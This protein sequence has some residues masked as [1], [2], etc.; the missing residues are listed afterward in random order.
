MFKIYRDL[1]KLEKERKSISVAI[2]GSGKMGVSLLSLLIKL[3][4]FDP[5]ILV[6]RTLSKAEEAYRRFGIKNIARVSSIE[7][8][9]KALEA[10]DYLVSADYRIAVESK[11]IDVVVDAT[12]IPELGAEI[13]LA[14]F[15]NKK[16]VVMLNVECDAVIGPILR[17]KAMEAGVVYTGTK[18]DEPGAI[19]DLV[20]F[21]QMIGAE[22]QVVGKGKNNKLDPYASQES[23]KIDAENKK[24]SQ[25][26]MTSFVDGTNT[27]IE[28]T[29]VGNALGF[30]PDI[31]GCHGVEAKPETCAKIFSLKKDG[32][33]LSSLKTVDF[34]FGMA[35][36]VF[37]VVSSDNEEVR[38]ILT[39]LGF[40]EG[41]LFTLFRPYHL[42]SLETPIS[43]YNAVI[44]KETSI[45]A[46][47]GR[48]CDTI[49]VSK[50]DFAK[51]EKLEGIGSDKVFGRI[52]SRQD[53]EKG[54][55][56]PIGLINDKTSFKV[57]VKKGQHIT[58]DMVELDRD[59]LLT[60]LR[61]EQD[62]LGL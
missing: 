2:V 56:L 6:N 55:Y 58:Y 37:A 26:M 35:P 49:A 7:E 50:G 19:V 38:D 46:E 40:G 28:L 30:T 36:G 20:E 29:S 18:G 11:Q 41:P 23:L 8:S 17:K 24:L 13:C 59:S 22:V 52:V 57:P 31:E 21:A 32:G 27:M 42:I 62:K 12:G 53:Q 60:R 1:E 34:S 44:L 43:I 3:P 48:I 9:R 15:E 10:G 25:R 4:G 51:G 54:N 5:K 47:K 33:I 39:Y 45:S 14:C 16:H 61:M